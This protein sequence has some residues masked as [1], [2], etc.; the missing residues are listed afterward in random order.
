MHSWRPNKEESFD[1]LEGYFQCLRLKELF[2]DI[3]EQIDVKEQSHFRR[4][5]MWM[6]TNGGHPAIE[7][8]IKKF[9]VD[10]QQQL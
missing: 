5:G 10:L 8:Y 7:I 3:D 6:P 9:R 2:L 1:D 4:Q